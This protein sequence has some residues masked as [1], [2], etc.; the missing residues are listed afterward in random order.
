VTTVAPPG[1]RHEASDAQSRARPEHQDRRAGKT[2]IASQWYEVPRLETR[3]RTRDRL[4]IVHHSNGRKPERRH[5]RN[6]V[7]RPTAVGEFGVPGPNR[8]CDCD[9]RSLDAP[10]AEKNGERLVEVPVV[11]HGKIFHRPKLAADAQG[12][13]RVG[14]A[15]V[16]EQQRC[17]RVCRAVQHGLYRVDLPQ[18]MR[19]HV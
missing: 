7:D 5:Q 11:R 8:A 16:G 13:A 18:S 4:E 17:I 15:D 3:Q 1:A 12:E 10:P 14:A 19:G 2:R 9:H 6:G